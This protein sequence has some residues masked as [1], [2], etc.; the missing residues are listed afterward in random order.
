VCSRAWN[1]KGDEPVLVIRRDVVRERGRRR[2]ESES[3]KGKGHSFK[4]SSLED[5]VRVA[6]VTEQCS[7]GYWR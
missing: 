7:Y 5:R 6:C 2:I 1:G 3:R 4:V